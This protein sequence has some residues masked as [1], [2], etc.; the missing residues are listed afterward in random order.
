MIKTNNCWKRK[1]LVLVDDWPWPREHKKLGVA[2]E[3]LNRI[4][5]M[6]NYS[7]SLNENRE[8]VVQLPEGLNE[9]PDELME[10]WTRRVLVC[11]LAVQKTLY[12]VE[13]GKINE[14]I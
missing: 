14:I 6:S 12:L 7:F 5:W 8:I 10:M 3:V 4:Y 11:C 2:V 9:T 1:T 13:T